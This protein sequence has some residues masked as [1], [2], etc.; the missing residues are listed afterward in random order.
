MGCDLDYR[1]GVGTA[2]VCD[3]GK[4]EAASECVL[5][6]GR[7]SGGGEDEIDSCGEAV[8]PRNPRPALRTHLYVSLVNDRRSCE[9]EKECDLWNAVGATGI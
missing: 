7:A 1:C 6:L 4:R 8:L 9:V 5:L 3:L 2:G